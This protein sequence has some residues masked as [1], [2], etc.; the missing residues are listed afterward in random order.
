MG[1]PPVLIHLHS[2]M[3]MKYHDF[4]YHPAMNGIP[5]MET[6]VFMASDL[7]TT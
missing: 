6:Q 4:F 5:F 3:S 7:E 2:W 1:V